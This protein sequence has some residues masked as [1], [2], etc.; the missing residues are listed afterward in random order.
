[1]G[2][3]LGTA[4]GLAFGAAT[5]YTRARAGNDFITDATKAPAPGKSALVAEIDEEATGLV[6]ARIE[7]KTFDRAKA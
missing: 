1:V 2:I 5:D 6:A 4:T 3:A 7:V